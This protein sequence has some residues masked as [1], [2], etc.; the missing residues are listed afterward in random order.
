MNVK[1]V[2]VFVY[3]LVLIL[4]FT[5]AVFSGTTGKI[6]GSI[7][8]QETGQPLPGANITITGTLLGAAADVNGNY[9]ILHV[10]PGIYDIQASMIGYTKVIMSNIRVMIDQTAKADFEL[11]PE[12]ISGEE[13]TIV[14]EKNIIKEDVATSV[15][16][17]S[18]SEVETLPLTSVEEVVELQ[19][20]VEDGLVIR[21]GGADETL[22]L[23][24]GITLRDPRNNQPITGISL[25]A[26]KEISVE[27][28]GFN[29]EYGQVR[30]GLINVITKEGDRNNYWGSI[31]LKASPPAAKHFGLSPYDKNSMW[32]KPYLDDAVCWTGTQNGVWDEYTARQYPI[33]RGWDVVSQELLQD[34]DPTNDL[35]PEAAQRLFDWEYRKQPVTD[36]PD[37]NI[38]AGFGGPVP[39][40][41]NKLGNLRFF[42]SYRREREMLLVPLT[43]DD[44]LE[45]NW[46][47]KMTSDLSSSMK[48]TLSGLSGKFYTVAANEGDHIYLTNEFG[49]N[50]NRATNY[51]HP[52]MFLRTP[53]DIAKVT[54]EQRS[55]RIFSDSW[56]S[57]AEVGHYS[58]AARLIH[59]LNPTTFY[60]A[61]IE[62]LAREYLT[63]PVEARD[64]TRK[65]EIVPGYYV[66]EAPSGWSPYSTGGIGGANQFFGGHTGE[67]RDSSRISA[68]TLKLDLTSQ[69]NFNN[70]AKVGLEFV[71]NDLDLR[72][73]D[74]NAFTSRIIMVNEHQFPYR[75]AFYAQDKLEALGF[76][77]NAG[78]RLDFSNANGKWVRPENIY[79]KSYFSSDYDPHGEYQAEDIKTEL[80][81]SP[82]LG[83]SHPITEN[84]K[85]FFNYGHFKQL[86][87]YE[88]LL[89]LGRAAGGALKNY[90]DPNMA[91]A[92]TISYELGYD[93]VL[94]NTLLVQ[95]AA[96]YHDVTDQLSYTTYAS[97]DGS[98]IYSAATND[99]YEDIRGFELSLNKSSGW[100]SGFAN[101]TY[102]VNTYGYF[103]RRNIYENLSEQRQ[104]DENTR[105]LYQGKPIPQPYARVSM[106]L[107]SPDGFGP[108]FLGIDPLEDCT[109]NLLYFWR[110]GEYID[111][112]P[113]NRLEVYDNV[114]VRDY[115]NMAL[116]LNKTFN[117]STM[118]LTLFMEVE[119][120]LNTRRLSGA[121]FYDGFDYQYYMES[122]HLT[123]S[124]DYDN[125]VGDDRPGD[126]RKDG[127]EFQPIEQIG[128]TADLVNPNL[129]VIYYERNSGKYMSYAEE[130][131]WAEVNKGKMQKILDDKAYIDMPNQ[132]SFSFL[133]PR[134]WFF[135]LKISFDL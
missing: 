77:L 129:R 5:Q 90:G 133:N 85:L 71:Y 74:V 27:R 131:G 63:G 122:L 110:A 1:R 39:F 112:N 130:N 55:G 108:G 94:F 35:T 123:A 117:I 70:L 127:V 91:L 26:V 10:P 20:G 135:G 22:Y 56:Y 115:H 51:W 12:V 76:I 62:H 119:N 79:D 41:A 64:T 31:T 36:Q 47:L 45:H 4:L 49:P 66:D 134:Q 111:W 86:P 25:S 40:I 92:K 82:R 9:V 93:H 52:T 88:E 83:I 113:F 15:V 59:T 103:G 3:S 43:R 6:S 102:Q 80:S 29:A 121:G 101:Y 24:D 105:L 16:A 34:N 72:Y 126:Y 28:G 104:Y 32:M 38:D 46:N 125:L 73:G 128:N 89:R 100:W 120:L 118:R 42:A 96:F 44:Y 7:T 23:L 53:L 69:L 30:S 58:F 54:A 75:G 13:V 116:R 114:Q 132:S 107:R 78:L 106:M 11:G 124:K 98:V 97:A 95:A 33:F 68:T 81:L 65:Y 57:G 8:D 17:I 2:G 18:E 50:D 61:S 21:G 60:E 84:S 14:A 67:A 37:Y 109:L 99:S 48:L 87:T 19:A